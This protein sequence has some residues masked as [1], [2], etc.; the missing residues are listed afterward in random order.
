MKWSTEET[1]VLEI[2]VQ[3]SDTVQTAPIGQ[4][5][6][7]RRTVFSPKSSNGLFKGFKKPQR[8]CERDQIVTLRHGDIANKNK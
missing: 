6:G 4:I 1:T 3:H 2:T 7:S 8:K 5:D